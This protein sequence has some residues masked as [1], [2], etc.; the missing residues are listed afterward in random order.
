MVR[1]HDRLLVTHKHLMYKCESNPSFIGSLPEQLPSYE[2]K[3]FTEGITSRLQC[4]KKTLE[5]HRPPKMK[6]LLHNLQFLKF[7]STLWQLSH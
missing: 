3:F 6:H 2:I 7:P 4:L 1:A 5:E